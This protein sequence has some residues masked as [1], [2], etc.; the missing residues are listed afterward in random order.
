CLQ[1]LNRELQFNIGGLEDS[2]TL[3]ADVEKLS[4]R[5]QTH[6]SP[7]LMYAAQFW[8]DHLQDV[9]PDQEILSELKEFIEHHFLYWLEV[10]SLRDQVSI[11]TRSLNIARKHAFGGGDA[12]LENFIQDIL[13]FV[14]TFAPLIARS[15]PHI[16]ISALP[17]APRQS[18]IWQ[19][20]SSSFPKTL[21]CHGASTEN[22]PNIQKELRGYPERIESI[23]SS[24][25]GKYIVSGSDDKTIRV[26]DS[27]TGVLAGK[28]EGHTDRVNS[29][30]FSPDSKWIVS[31][32]KDNTVR[33][34]DSE[35][36]MATGKFTEHTRDVISV[37]F[38]PDGKWIVSGSKDQTIR[39]WD[40]ETGMLSRVFEGHRGGVTSV[41]FSP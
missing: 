37:V 9:D 41:A 29:V 24:P 11:A 39:L 13:K 16:Y 36:G 12:S 38:S 30:A 22:W 17:F 6:I 2:R 18:R 27:E 15:V 31:G 20:F 23:A 14:A 34:W 28:F 8:S 1:V 10:L 25:D 35:T 7:H 40:S 19:Q 26:W 32:S 33:V 21:R 5:I 4:D 3:N